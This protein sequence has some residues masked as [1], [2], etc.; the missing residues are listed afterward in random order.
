M[1]MPRLPRQCSGNGETVG[2]RSRGEQALGR[3][4][5]STDAP[6]RKPEINENCCTAD[7]DGPFGLLTPP[8]PPPLTTC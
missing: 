4:R 3:E 7:G 6:D 2:T 5:S 8:P 1:Q